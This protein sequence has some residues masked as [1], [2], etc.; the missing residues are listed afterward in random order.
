M[1][2][3]WIAHQAFQKMEYLANTRCPNETGGMLLGYVATSGEVVVTA[4]IGP[5]PAGKHHRYAFEP[6]G[7]HQQAEFE[8]HYWAT[9]GRESYLGDWHTHPYGKPN[10][11]RLD[12]RTLANIA[13]TPS[14][15]IKHPVMAIL[16]GSPDNWTLG[17]VRF[18]SMT[19]RLFFKEYFL[20]TLIPIIFDEHVV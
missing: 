10:L 1:A 15:G 19:R 18:L 6:D 14:S 11:S 5:G 8:A 13:N 2:K 12:K 20:E 16:G 3:F 7:E 4:I 9:E 17:T